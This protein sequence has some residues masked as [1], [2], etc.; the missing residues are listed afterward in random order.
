MMI[1]WQMHSLQTII[2]CLLFTSPAFAA[3]EAPLE[4]HRSPKG[5]L[6][7]LVE[8]HPQKPDIVRLEG[9]SGKV[10][11]TLAVDDEVKDGEVK[12]GSVLW[13]AA[14]DGVAFAVGNS[15][16][17]YAHAFIRTTEGW[18][19]LKLPEPGDGGKTVFD[20][21]HSVPSAWQGNRLTLT[22][23]GPHAGQA[24]AAAYQGAITVAVDIEGG[25]AKKVAED[26]VTVVPG[27]EAR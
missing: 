27:K 11:L 19:H 7:V 25:S 8:R 10:F 12:E 15:R 26:I 22:V 2:C 20:S 18:K 9:A 13:N 21:Y 6:N 14:G 24:G 23:T 4:R 1:G 5:D 16:L 3:G 17:L